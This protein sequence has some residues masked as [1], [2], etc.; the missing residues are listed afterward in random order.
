MLTALLMLPWTPAQAG[1]F[2]ESGFITE[3]S[4]KGFFIDGAKHRFSPGAKL[5]NPSK[6]RR[7]LDDLK[8]GDLISGRGVVV[9][10]VR[11]IEVVTFFPHVP[12]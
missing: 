5:L 6:E 10:G 2:E 8:P 12:N 9:S 11:Y 1:S 3:I 7:K 4:L